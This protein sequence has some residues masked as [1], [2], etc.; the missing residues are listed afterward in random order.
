MQRDRRAGGHA[1][2]GKRR[3]GSAEPECAGE[4]A[5]VASQTTL[6]VEQEIVRFPLLQRRGAFFLHSALR[7]DGSDGARREGELHQCANDFRIDRGA[8]GHGRDV[9]RARERS[10]DPDGV[11]R[12]QCKPCVAKR[13]AKRPR[14]LAREG[15]ETADAI[16]RSRIERRRVE[17]EAV[18]GMKRRQRLPL[19]DGHARER[20]HR[21]QL[22]QQKVKSRQILAAFDRAKLLGQAAFFAWGSRKAL[23]HAPLAGAARRPFEPAARRGH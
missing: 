17:R 4:R 13:G 3:D 5:G 15:R 18:A 21:V 23:H 10:H 6:R 1:Q 2:R 19:M 16:G 8:C 7:I 14:V 12:R 22:E 11:A 9:A 20:L